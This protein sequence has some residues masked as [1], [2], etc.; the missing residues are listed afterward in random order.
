M[1]TNI[2]NTFMSISPNPEKNRGR[3]F[4]AVGSGSFFLGAG[5]NKRVSTKGLSKNPALEGFSVAQE[6]IWQGP[7]R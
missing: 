5:I 6:Y 1:P 2:K 7:L 4:L 3:L